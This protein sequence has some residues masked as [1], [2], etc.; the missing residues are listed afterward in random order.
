MTS[1]NM[2]RRGM[3]FGLKTSQRKRRRGNNNIF[4]FYQIRL[5]EFHAVFNIIIPTGIVDSPDIK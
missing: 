2:I 1:I 5:P 3:L 4:F